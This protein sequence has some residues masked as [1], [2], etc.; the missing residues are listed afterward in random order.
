ML[1][2]CLLGEVV[3]RKRAS[4]VGCLSDQQFS[5]RNATHAWV[6]KINVEISTINLSNK[7]QLNR[8]ETINVYKQKK[9]ILVCDTSIYWELDIINDDIQCVSFCRSGSNS[10]EATVS[11]H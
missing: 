6:P 8:I 7:V 2:E 3:A 4:A 1:G 11:R 5:H 10:L 9:Q